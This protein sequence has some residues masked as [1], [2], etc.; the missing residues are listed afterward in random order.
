MSA[1]R[2]NPSW[3]KT[4]CSRRRPRHREGARISGMPAYEALCKEAEKDFEGFWARLARENLQWTKPFTRRRWTSP[5]R[6]STS[7]SPTASSTPAPTAWTAHRHA[8]REQDRHHLRGRRRQVTNVT[9][10]ELLARVSQFANALKAR[11]SR[12][13]TASSSTC[14]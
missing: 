11:A 12:R 7:G 3:S 10:K 1:I 2:S 13:A 4:A 14:R 8:G 5:R 6:R 9:Y